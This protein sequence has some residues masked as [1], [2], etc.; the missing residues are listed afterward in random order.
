MNLLIASGE[1]RGGG[2]GGRERE[3]D[4]WVRNNYS[5][6]STITI[7][8]E[9]LAIQHNES[10]TISYDFNTFNYLTCRHASNMSMANFT[11]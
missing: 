5:Q 1:G 2:G 9:W 10:V 8:N 6:F 7:T 3:R 4:F 11:S